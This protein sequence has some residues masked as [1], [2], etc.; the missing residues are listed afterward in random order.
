MNDTQLTVTDFLKTFYGLTY[1]VRGDIRIIQQILRDK[2]P[3]TEF[4]AKYISYVGN[5]L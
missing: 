2:R 5:P 1:L 4:G 3:N